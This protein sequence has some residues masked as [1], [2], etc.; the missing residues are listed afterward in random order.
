MN[1]TDLVLKD[2]QLEEPTAKDSEW[3]EKE[4]IVG[5]LNQGQVCSH[6]EDTAMV[7]REEVF[8]PNCLSLRSQ[9]RHYAGTSR[10]A[11]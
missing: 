10:P 8:I 5:C 4:S 7:W 6:F 9:L 11:V 3:I 2:T 1:T